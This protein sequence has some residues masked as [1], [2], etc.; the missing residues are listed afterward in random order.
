MIASQP[1]FII[2][3]YS[4]ILSTPH[5]NLKSKYCT[6]VF[7]I[8]QAIATNNVFCGH[9]IKPMFIHI[10]SSALIKSHPHIGFLLL[11]LASICSLPPATVTSNLPPALLCAA[12]FHSHA[13]HDNQLISSVWAYSEMTTTTIYK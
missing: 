4:E 13:K 11:C 7:C 10:P 1:L 6:I 3:R 5:N 12:S 2:G 9:F 8:N